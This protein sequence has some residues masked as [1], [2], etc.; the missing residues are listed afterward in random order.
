MI[1]RRVDTL[2][3]LSYN[4]RVRNQEESPLIIMAILVDANQI[5]ISHLMVQHK[6]DDGINIDKVR[7]S[8]VRVLGRIARQFKEYG[9]MI[10]CYDD[11]QYWRREAFPFYKKNR[12]QE[13]ESSKYDWTEVFSVLNIIRDEVKA[14]FPYQVIQVDGAEADDVIASI[15]I[16]NQKTN[17][18]EP[19]LILSADKDFIQLHKHDAV[20]QYDPIRN[21]WIENENP[22]QYLQE[23][24]IKGDRSDGIP[25][26]LTCDDA[27][28]NG[29]PQK[30]MSKE[31]ISSLASMNPDDFT[32]FIRLRN[33]KR[34]SVLIDFTN[35]PENVVER[36]LTT[37]HQKVERDT[38]D[39]N[40]FVHHNI[41]TLI[42]EFS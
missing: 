26:I 5:A 36:I 1:I 24:I 27:I 41:G 14:N 37:Y 30:K 17:N 3:F 28:V 33:W 2:L 35:I 11:K 20:S 39:I 31:K 8:I 21:R 34:N 13:R 6:I 19:M 12:K 42:E 22:V 16:F 15:C 18:P 29:K 4:K 40:Y 10:L 23:H 25:N 38:I 32:N 7:F 9:D